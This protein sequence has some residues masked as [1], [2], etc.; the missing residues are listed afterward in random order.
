MAVVNVGGRT[1]EYLLE[2]A[3]ELV[4]FSSPTWW[5][6]DAW[7]LSGVPRLRASHR[8]LAFN[9]RGIGASQATP[10]PYTNDSLAEDMLAL[11]DALDVRQPADVI[12]FANGCSV[13]LRAAARWPQR[14]R[15]LVLAAAGAGAPA[16]ASRVAHEKAEIDRLGYR[17]FIR[18]H[19]LNDDFAFSPEHYRRHPDR[20]QALADALW[21]HQGPEEEYLKH[22]EARVGY[23]TLD[24]AREVRQPCLVLC[25]EEDN[26]ARGTSTP[27]RFAGELAAGLPK[28]QL[29]LLPGI[30][31]MTFWEDPDLAWAEVHAFLGCCNTLV[32]GEGREKTS[33]S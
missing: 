32:G 30:R 31:H 13:A 27:V 16:S 1:V 24:L 8:L 28:G 5:P 12:G 17:E 6:L 7:L 25:G 3:G 14:V 22:V 21:E 19:A 20:G 23:S 26:V 10:G 33:P 29:K 15:S 18:H 9:H 11:M 4:V 2:G